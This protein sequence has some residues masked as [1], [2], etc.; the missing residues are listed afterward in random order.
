[1]ENVLTVGRE[2]GRL[3]EANEVISSMRKR[4][5][6]I[7]N[8]A[9]QLKD[10]PRVFCMEWLDPIF[11]GGHWVPEMVQIAGGTEELGR[12]HQPS[13]RIDWNRVL[14]YDPDIIILMPCGFDL[15][16]TV[17][18]SKLVK[19]GDSLEK[20]RAVKNGKVFAVN[21]SAYF[22]RPGPRI[23]DGLEIM[24]QI[25][26]PNLFRGLAPSES[27]IRLALDNRRMIGA[28]SQLRRIRR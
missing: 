14:D 27:Y 17:A 16:R 28:A 5:M 19:Y 9:G 12:V 4:I 24:A 13:I 25:L 6:R 21:G 26:H 3:R 11:V 23:V 8:A 1:M 22:N 15:Q 2:T 10:R 18:E 20:L 7:E